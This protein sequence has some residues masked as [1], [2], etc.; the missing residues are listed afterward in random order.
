MRSASPLAAIASSR[1]STSRVT[2]LLHVGDR[3]RRE[4]A[5]DDAAHARV[6]RRIVEHQARG[7]VLEEQAVAV[8]GR[9]LA[10]LVGGEGGASL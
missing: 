8:L 10:L 1:P 4:G 7:V 2:G 5:G 6:Q 3:A 9:E